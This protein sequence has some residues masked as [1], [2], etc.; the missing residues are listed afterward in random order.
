MLKKVAAEIKRIEECSRKYIWWF[1]L[2]TILAL[3]LACIMIFQYA[4][5]KLFFS[6]SYEL[7]NAEL[8]K[9]IEESL[10]LKLDAESVTQITSIELDGYKELNALVGIEPVSYTHLDVYKRQL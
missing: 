1:I 8:Q 7:G 4:Q 3:G 2:G 10:N 9:A 6:E 5:E